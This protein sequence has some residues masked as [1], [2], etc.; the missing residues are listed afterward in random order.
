[1]RKYSTPFL[2]Q[3]FSIRSF[4]IRHSGSQGLRFRDRQFAASTRTNR[5]NYLEKGTTV[6]TVARCRWTLS[7]SWASSL[8]TGP[9]VAE[10]ST[11]ERGIGAA[12]RRRERERFFAR[13]KREISPRSEPGSAYCSLLAAEREE[14][15]HLLAARRDPS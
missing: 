9:S 14:R 5:I 13:I 15:S 6:D 3:I 11:V 12:R 10:E 8:W 7:S 2:S 4:V 1:M